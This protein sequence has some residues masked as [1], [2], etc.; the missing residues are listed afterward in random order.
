[1]QDDWVDIQGASAQPNPIVDWVMP[2][3]VA[4][5]SEIREFDFLPVTTTRVRVLVEN[6]TTE[7][8][9]WMDEIEAYGPA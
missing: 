5:G 6:G 1:M 3:N 4:D 2:L 7:G 9:S 8:W